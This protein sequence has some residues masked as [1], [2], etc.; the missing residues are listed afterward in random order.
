MRKGG[1]T[2]NAVKGKH[3]CCLT[4]LPCEQIINAVYRQSTGFKE[5]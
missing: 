5:S 1:K 3:L 4:M 2:S